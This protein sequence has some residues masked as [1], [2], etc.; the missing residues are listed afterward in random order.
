MSAPKDRTSTQTGSYYIE[1]VTGEK[2]TSVTTIISGG[3]PKPALIRWAA[4]SVAEYAVDEHDKWAGL[5]R[6]EAVDLLKGSP[7]RTRDKAADLG[8]SIHDQVEA[9][10]LGRPIPEPML[11]A[12]PYVA[13]FRAFCEAFQPEWEASEI[14]VWSPT[15]GYAGT[16][17]AIATIAGY[18]RLLIDVKTGKGVWGEAGLQLAAY[19]H[20][21]YVRWPDGSKQPVPEVDGCAVLH[22]SAHTYE[23]LPVQADAEMFT[24]FLQAKAIREWVA[25]SK[26]VVGAPLCSPRVLAA[27]PADPLAG[28]PGFDPLLDKEVAR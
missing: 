28:I 3:I 27:Q 4:K 5:D 11:P 23:L 9:M 26:S 25:R 19:R 22:L 7:Y 16:L 24:A 1:P 21:D 20:A 14:T 8:S 15:H 17:D 10:I 12:R 6:D 2:M 18:G 13:Q